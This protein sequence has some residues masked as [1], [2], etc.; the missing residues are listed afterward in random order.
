MNAFSTDSQCQMLV[1]AVS[2]ELWQRG[3]ACRMWFYEQRDA[4][5]PA[6]CDRVIGEHPDSIVWLTP[7]PRITILGQRLMNCGIRVVRGSTNHQSA[8]SLT[9]QFGGQVK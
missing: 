9:E 8:S 2:D 3:Y 6:F 5:E 4:N 1:K 7:T